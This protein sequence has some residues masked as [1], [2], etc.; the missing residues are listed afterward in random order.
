[1]SIHSPKIYTFLM[2]LLFWMRASK[3]AQRTLGLSGNPLLLSR[4]DYPLG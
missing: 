3:A 1:M 2:V 4:A